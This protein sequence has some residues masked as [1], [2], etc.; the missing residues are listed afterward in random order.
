VKVGS[1][2][3]RVSFQQWR[4]EALNAVMSYGLLNGETVVDS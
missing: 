2:E 1:F 4:S 3:T